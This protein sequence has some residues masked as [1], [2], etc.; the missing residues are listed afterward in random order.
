MTAVLD[1]PAPL[2]QGSGGGLPARL[3]MLRWA[4]RLFRREWRQQSAILGLIVLA[5]AATLVGSAVAINSP[6]PSDA[7]FGTAGYRATFPGDDAHLSA[8]IA[9]L[10]A[11]YGPVD[12][13]ESQSLQVPGSVLDYEL[14]AQ[15]PNGPY[16]QP[17]ISLVSGRYPANAHEVAMTSGLL[18]QLGL[19]VGQ[20][21]R[22]D[23]TTR[24]VV[25]VVLNTQSYLDNFALVL[26]GQVTSP[27]QVTVLFDAPGV[28][29]HSIGKNVSTPASVASSNPINPESI[30]IAALTIGMLLIALVSI[31]G[32]T[33]LAQRRTRSFGML[34]AIGAT[35]RNVRLVVRANGVF[36]GVV[37]AAAGTVLGLALWLVYRPHLEQS[38]HH[39]IAVLALPWLVVVLAVAL[40]IAATYFASSR[41]ARAIARISVISA[42]SGRPAPPARVRRS[43]I[44]GVVC[45]VAAFLLLG[46]SGSSVGG[47]G[48]GGSLELVLGL[49]FLIPAM[50]LLAPFFLVLFARVGR[51]API[52]PR[53]ALRDLARYRARSGSA[54]AAISVGVLIAVIV[55]TATASRYGDVFD[56]AGPNVATNELLVYVGGGP[57]GPSQDLL[58][59]E[60]IAAVGIGKALGAEHVVELDSSPV[61]LGNGRGK[62]FSSPIFV[63]TPQLLRAFGIKASNVAADA[64]FLSQ[65]PGLAGSSGLVATWCEKAVPLGS[66]GNFG[67]ASNGQLNN[68]VIQ[69]EGNL[70]SGIH[71][72]NTVL[73]EHAVDAFGVRNQITVVGWLIQAAQPFT[74]AQ[75]HGAQGAAAAAGMSIESHDD[76]PTSSEIIN[77]AT[78][79]GIILALCILAMSV[80]LLRSETAS[81]LR[82]LSATGATSYT[83]RN[84]TAA[85]AGAL[86][87]LGALIGTIGGYVA[88]I[89]WLRDNSLNGGIASLGNVP[90]DNLVV[91]LIGMPVLATAAAWLLAGREPAEM[92]RQPIE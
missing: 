62:Y 67:C 16:G 4:R 31:G 38:A 86:G 39:E 37:G 65:I 7:G 50:I 34:T 84:L 85:T 74:P 9:E 11:R 91:L 46:Y 32:F 23:G 12:V 6:P 13:I 73:T 69:G 87:F 89:G 61:S 20:R 47:T 59:S 44:P 49:F 8:Q 77:S 26:P 81:E 28:S 27:T 75:L 19:S 3:A 92:A 30:S 21:W 25:G 60:S 2:A 42:L 29:P 80:G 10:D 76:E 35:D 68:P 14:R 53:L 57:N 22:H 58:R 18:S 54:L 52:A 72:P 33:V 78:L 90:V 40:A 15:D 79:F 64:D 17:L 88:M 66:P 70:P 51:R 55:A 56:L 82:T 83:R 45:L 63:G 48:S 71:A 5:V 41:P 36:V 43:A 1:P 24:Q